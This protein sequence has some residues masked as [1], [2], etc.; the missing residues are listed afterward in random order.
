M[1]ACS[2][3]PTAAPNPLAVAAGVG[4]TATTTTSGNVATATIP[5]VST[6]AGNTQSGP[7]VSTEANPGSRPAVL[8]SPTPVGPDQR[9]ILKIW[10][11]GWK[12]NADYEN[13]LNTTIDS[14]RT[15]Y[16]KDFTLD[17]QDYGNDL[18][19]QLSN[20]ISK[21]QAAVPDLVLLN[22]GDLY[23]FAATEKL[24]D[25][26]PLIGTEAQGRYSIPAW[27]ALRYTS[28]SISGS[29]GLPWIASTRISIINKKLWQLSTLDPAKLPKNFDELDKYLPLMRDKTPLDVRAVWLHPDPVADLLMEGTPLYSLNS[30]GKKEAAF[31]VLD[32]QSKWQYYLNRRRDGYFSNEALEGTYK[33]ALARYSAGKLVMVMDGATLLPDLKAQNLD[34]YN[35]TLV[36]LH[37]LSKGNVLPMQIQGWSIPKIASAKNKKEAVQFA[38]YLDNEENQLTFAKLVKVAIPTTKKGLNDPYV[39]GNDEPLTQARA[40]M[41]Q[42][43]PQSRPAE[44][45]IPAPIPFATRDKMLNALYIAQGAVWAKSVGPKEAMTEAAKIWIELLK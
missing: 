40:I 7:S 30:D 17:W 14:Y 37:P 1:G 22:P 33:D 36:T 41:A 26:G 38:L 4:V 21:G 8:V 10:T 35:N 12:G 15:K 13:F 32:A 5:P 23:Q 31:N 29:Y 44:Q 34:L 19:T 20:A 18:A 45:L 42:A 28:G 16:A 27:E 43:F 39:L 11:N 24:E 3:T 25:L 2:E 6:Q 9:V